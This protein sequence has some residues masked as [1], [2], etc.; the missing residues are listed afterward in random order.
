MKRE[1]S[2][3][4]CL[5]AGPQYAASRL[6]PAVP[7]MRRHERSSRGQRTALS[8]ATKPKFPSRPKRTFVSVA[9]GR[10]ANAL[11]L[12]ESSVRELLAESARSLTPRLRSRGSWGDWWFGARHGDHERRRCVHAL[13]AGLHRPHR[14]SSALS[15]VLR[16]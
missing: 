15:S 11:C 7:A 14:C 1:R 3:M 8:A 6:L 2:C 5:T 10:K 13:A 16:T 12:G 9:Y 4:P